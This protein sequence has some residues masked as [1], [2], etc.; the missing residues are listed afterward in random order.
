MYFIFIYFFI[1]NNFLI[2]L[3]IYV[4]ITSFHSKT[5]SISVYAEGNSIYFI[6]KNRF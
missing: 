1:F 6:I 5:V 3:A 2:Y 4:N